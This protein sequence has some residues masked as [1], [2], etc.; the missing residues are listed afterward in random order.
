MTL[1]TAVVAEVVDI[2]AFVV[3][4]YKSVFQQ[5]I[6]NR[7]QIALNC[8]HN[9]LRA[10]IG[11]ILHRDF[12]IYVKGHSRSLETEPFDKIIHGLL[13]DDYYLM[14]NIIVALKCGSEVTQVFINGTI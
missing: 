5:E 7:K 12:E 2:V 1:L 11:Y 6:S 13:L 14:L 3:A 9:T 4:Q 8:A 10:S